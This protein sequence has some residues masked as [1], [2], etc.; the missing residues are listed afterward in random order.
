M[1]KICLLLNVEYLCLITRL[2]ISP[3]RDAKHISVLINGKRMNCL[4]KLFQITCTSICQK[5]EKGQKYNE[6]VFIYTAWIEILE[7]FQLETQHLF[8]LR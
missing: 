1:C 8:W 3:C 4:P 6:R 2:D 5:V 7:S